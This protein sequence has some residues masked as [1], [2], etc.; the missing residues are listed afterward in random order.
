MKA[1]LPEVW[2]EDPRWKKLT[3]QDKFIY[4]PRDVDPGQPKIITDDGYLLSGASNRIMI[5][6]ALAQSLGFKTP[7]DAI[8]ERL[9]LSRAVNSSGRLKVAL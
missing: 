2:N 6:E 8:H 9:P 4:V 3:E 1:G 5:N 7:E